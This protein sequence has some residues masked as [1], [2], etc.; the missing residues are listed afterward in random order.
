MHKTIRQFSLGLVRGSFTLLTIFIA[1]L[2]ISN[3]AKADVSL[4]DGYLFLHPHYNYAPTVIFDGNIQQ[5]WWCGQAPQGGDVIYYRWVDV[6]AQSWSPIYE[7]LAP[8][9]GTWDGTFTCDPSVV[10]GNFYNPDDGINYSYAM[11]YTATDC[12]FGTNNRIGVAFSEDGLY[13]TKYSGNPIVS[14]QNAVGCSSQEVNFHAYGA[15]QASTYNSNGQAGIYLFHTDTSAASPSGSIV[16]VR[17]TSDGI[18]FG[19]PTPIS[20]QGA[21]LNGNDDFAFD[22]S[23]GYFYAALSMP[24]RSTDRETYQIGLYRMNANTLVSGQ[25]TWE[26]VAIVDS[27]LTGYYLNHSPGILRD[28]YGNVTPWLPALEI[29]FAAGTND[30]DTWNLTFAIWDLQHTTLPFNR[31]FSYDYGDHWVTTGKPSTS[32]YLE[33]T[34]GY[35][36]ESPAQNTHPI[37]GCSINTGH[38]VSLDPNCEGQFVLG[39]NGWAFDSPPSGISTVPL[40]RCYDGSDHFVSAD[41]ACEGVTTEVLLGY[42]RT[43]PN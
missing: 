30:T 37:Y 8:T 1:I 4:G 34:L 15:G 11:Y 14:P 18:N 16:W 5:F 43:D 26:Q 40:W 29:Y 9:P 2:A 13:W 38:F 39:T 33:Y 21:P 7:V 35:L 10:R 22:Y 19:S 3:T 23:S 42:V 36:L 25:G 31:Y 20:N 28:I 32:Y 41:P 27:N 24:L 6:P 17:S 12:P